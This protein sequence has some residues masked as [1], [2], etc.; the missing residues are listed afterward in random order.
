MK[1]KWWLGGLLVGLLAV[2]AWAITGEEIVNKVDANMTFKTA[3]AESKMVIHVDQEVREKTMISYDRGTDTGY[4][5]FLTPARD[6][7]VKYLKIKD[8]MWMYLPSVDKVIKIS[9]AMLRQ[10]MMGSDFSYEDALESTKLLE[11]YAATL[12][13][14]EV[15]PLTF[16]QG[17]QLVTKQRRC[18]VV[19]LT[20]KVKDV[21]YFRR[22]VYVDKELFVPAREEL[23]AL[24]GK[25]L[26]EMTMGD[27]RRFGTRYYPTYMTMSNLLRANSRTELF[28][29]RIDFDLTVNPVIFTQGNLT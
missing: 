11:K 1:Y 10:S 19:D 7:G 21:T 17:E 13:S 18:Y 4:A 20:A 9:G 24:S 29:T 12:I 5:E 6:K 26:K 25:K 23:F 16:R 27:V 22:V 3:R 15:I 14:E 2:R 28:T 8:N